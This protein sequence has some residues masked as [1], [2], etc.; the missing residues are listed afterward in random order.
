MQCIYSIHKYRKVN[1]FTIDNITKKM[2]LSMTSLIAELNSKIEIPYR[3]QL[4]I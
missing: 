4:L 2:N 1:H 3:V